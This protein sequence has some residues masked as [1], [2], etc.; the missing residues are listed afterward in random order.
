MA[1]TCGIRL[2]RTDFDLLILDG[3]TKK[4]N[5][6][7]CVTGEIP[8]DTEDPVAELVAALKT[9]T[10]GLK[11]P[12]DAIRVVGESGL[13]AFRNLVLPFDDASKIEQVIRFEVESDVPQWDIDDTVVDFHVASSTGVESHLINTIAPKAALAELLEIAT[14]AGL[15]PQELELDTTA[16]VNSAHR[17]GLL[18]VEGAQLLIHV[19]R[20]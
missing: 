18:T 9:A 6:V 3:S 15:E 4:P 2:G 13:A 10:K 14:K 5:V 7:A 8:Q 16:L 1:R 11:V 12:T 19:N 20:S 17:A